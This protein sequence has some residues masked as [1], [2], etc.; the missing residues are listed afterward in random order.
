MEVSPVITPSIW[1]SWI[2]MANEALFAIQADSPIISRPISQRRISLV[3]A[4]IS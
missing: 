4:P 3:P 2:K 1:H